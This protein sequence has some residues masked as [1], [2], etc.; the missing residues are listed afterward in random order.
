MRIVIA[1]GSGFLGRPLAESLGAAGHEVLVLSRHAPPAAGPGLVWD[2]TP[3]VRTAAWTGGD[4]PA[5]WG[6]AVDGAHAVVNLAGESIAARRWS[7]EHKARMRSSRL[8]STRGIGRA[9]AAAHRPPS[10]LVSSSATGYYGSRGDTR[11]VEQS[12]PGDDFLARLCVEW[13]AAAREAGGSATRVVLVRTGV[14]LARDG[15]ALAK[16]LLPFRLF[17]GGPMGSGGQYM[18]WIHRRDW[19]ALVT[20]LLGSAE[21]GPF[22]AT[23]PEP[24]TNADFSRELGRALGR[25]SWLPAP[26]FALKTLLGEMADSLLLSGQRVIPQR[27]LEGG[28]SFAFPS[29][30]LALADILS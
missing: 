13:E 22:N 10:V 6:H 7:D 19:L 26:A 28:F 2:G 18:S 25:P 24:V 1:G 16:M 9:I 21:D 30:E 11:L 8:D 20:W 12:A 14:V 29:L 3:G 23:A 4:D 15:G 27:A 5:G 17:A